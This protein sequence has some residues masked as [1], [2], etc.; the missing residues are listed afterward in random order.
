M[1][2]PMRSRCDVP[3]RDQHYEEKGAIDVRVTKVRAVVLTA[4]LAS[5][6]DVRHA[7][8]ICGDEVG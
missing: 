8:G 4:M 1:P 6:R 2:K 3:H 5:R 7:A